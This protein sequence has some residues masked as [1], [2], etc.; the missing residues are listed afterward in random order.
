[1]EKY[2]TLWTLRNEKYNSR[3]T[4]Y[5]LFFAELNDP[6]TYSFT[7]NICSFLPKLHLGFMKPAELC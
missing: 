4:L 6:I 1:M 2:R 5:K 3:A 7:N